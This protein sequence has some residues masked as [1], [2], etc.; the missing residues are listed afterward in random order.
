MIVSICIPTRNRARYL[1]ETIDSIV[2]DGV[3]VADYEVVISDNSDDSDTESLVCLYANKGFNVVYHRNPVKGFYNSVVALQHGRANFLK[4]HNDYTKFKPGEFL[5]FVNM[6]RELGSRRPLILFTD[7]NL[8]LW[9]VS[10]YDNFNDFISAS[11]Y[12]S[13]WSSAFS[14]WRDDLN[15]VL[16][17]VGVD[18]LNDQF[19]HTSILFHICNKAEYR[20]DDRRLFD[21][22]TV[23]KKGGYNI[24]Y[25]F[26][27]IYI[28]MLSDLQGRGLINQKTFEKIKYEMKMV[29]IP[30]WHSRTI[31][32]IRSAAKYSFDGADFKKNL[33]VHYSRLEYGQVIFLSFVHTLAVRVRDVLRL[34]GVLRM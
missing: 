9:N 31:G 22:L 4:L 5:S 30:Q 28:N 34:I 17:E 33:L 20:I 12:W 29:F 23:R 3:S 25:N 32:D 11:G 6:I 1:E 16:A 26:C 21:N 24:F 18:G 7:G 14:V 13:T 10:C 8:K 2:N 27:V 15:Y 19:P